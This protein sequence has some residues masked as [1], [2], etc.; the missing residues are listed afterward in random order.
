MVLKNKVY[1]TLKWIAMWLLPGMATLWLT[2]GKIWSFP[3]TTEIGATIS[4]IDVF[5][6]FILG[7]SNKNYQGDGTLNIDSSDPEKDTYNLELN[8]DVEELAN[9]KTI[10]FKVVTK[11]NE[12]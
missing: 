3:Y 9:K 6:A 11:A 2:L 12:D 7:L 8:D 10:T 5:L 1:D 4:A